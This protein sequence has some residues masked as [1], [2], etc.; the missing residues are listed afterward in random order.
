MRGSQ[1][2][3][4]QGWG[5]AHNRGRG[6][7]TKAAGGVRAPGHSR[8]HPQEGLVQQYTYCSFSHT[9]IFAIMHATNKPTN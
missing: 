2:K 5:P 7:K 4:K 1:D 8:A 9:Y 6:Q 3:G